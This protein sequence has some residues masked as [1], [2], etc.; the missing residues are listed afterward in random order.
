[1]TPEQF[2][3]SLRQPA[4][5]A[6]LPL[7]LQAL[8]FDALGNWAKA[9][10]LVQDEPGA[11]AALVHAY[12]H[13]REGDTANAAYWYNRAGSAFPAQTVEQEWKSLVQ[14]WLAP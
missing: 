12:L 9:H 3:D 4:P 11:D 2:I 14:K 10:E 1:M 13:R 8:W 5:P 6:A 7:H